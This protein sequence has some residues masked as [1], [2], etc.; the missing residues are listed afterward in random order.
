M[1]LPRTR[2]LTLIFAL[3]VLGALGG[4]ATYKAEPLALRPSWPAGVDRL[5]VDA[6]SM[7]LPELVKHTFDPRDGLDMTEVAML[8][9]ANNPQ[10]KVARANLGVARAQAY[11]AGLLPDPTFYYSPQRVKNG[12]AGENVTAFD[13]GVNFNLTALVLRSSRVSVAK[14]NARKAD[15]ALL[16]QEWQ[17]VSQARLLFVRDWGRNALLQI[18]QERRAIAALRYTREKAALADGNMTL[19]QVTLTGNM[20]QGIDKQIN[21]TERLI[22]KNRHALNALLGLSPDTRLNLVGPPTLP[23][24][25]R[26]AIAARLP[27]LAKR[28]PD[29]LALRAGYQAQDR[30]VRQAILAQFPKISF[31]PLKARDNTG[32]IYLGYSL[33][34]SLPIFN[35]NR[36]NIAIAN[37]TRHRMHEQF[38]LRLNAAYAQ[39][40]QLL[41]DEALLEQQAQTLDRNL[42]SLSVLADRAGA[43]LGAGNMSLSAY[44]NVKDR[45]TAKELQKSTLEETMLEERVALQTLVGSDLPLKQPK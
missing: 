18:L 27:E 17:V 35:G 20:L 37:A 23:A 24:L 21:Q 1:N 30:R 2:I 39:V 43:A 13:V 8:A 4:C 34:I 6:G 42:A 15:L 32:V 40:A 44:Y 36:G 33:S 11:A 3:P 45:Q 12:V 31:G 41:S 28:R 7:P 16:W 22:A 26:D 14:A 10:L 19:T 38:Q 5:Q 9:V 29:L 25:D